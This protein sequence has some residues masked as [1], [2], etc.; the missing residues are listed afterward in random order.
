MKLNSYQ[1]EIVD[2]LAQ[3]PQVIEACPGSGKTRTLENLVAA[4]VES[5]ADPLRI[6]IFTF[7]TKAAAEARK[8]IAGTL[9]P[10]ASGEELAFFENPKSNNGFSREW[11]EEKPERQ[12]LT[13]WTCTIHALSY[14]LLK[15]S[16]YKLRVLSGKAKWEA[17]NLIKDGLAELD[18]Q[19]SPKA[20]KLWISKAIIAL[21]Q[22]HEAMQW[23]AERLP[24]DVAWH[25]PDLAELYRR[26]SDFCKSRNLVDFDMMQSRVVYL[27]RNSAKFKT[28]A[29]SLFDYI[30]VDEAQDTSPQQAE[31]LFSLAQETGN[32]VFC[33]DVDQ[34]LFRFRGARPEVMRSDFDSIWPE[35]QRFNLPINYRSTQMIVRT[36]ATL[37]GQNYSNNGQYL[38]PFQSRPNAP[39]GQPVTYSEFGSFDQLAEEVSALVAQS[40][41]PGDWFVLSRTRAECAAIHTKLVANGLPAINKSG[42]MLFGS[43][44]IRKVLA[45]ARLA[46]NYQNSRDDLEI[47]GEIANVATVNFR[48]PWTRRRHLPGCNNTKSWVNCGCPIIAEEG[49]DYSHSRF[50]GQKAIEAAGSWQGVI[51]QLD[52]TNRGGFPTSRA[53]G[54]K[55]LVGFVERLETKTGAREC[56][57]VIIKDC[58]LPW[59]AA[60]EGV[61]DTDL[62]ENGKVEDFDVLLSLCDPEMTVEQFLDRVEELSQGGENGNEAESVLVGTC[63]WSKGAERPRVAVNITRMP[64]VPPTR[65]PGMLPTGSAPAIEEERRLLFVAMT[66]AKEECHLLGALEWNGQEQLQSQFIGEV[67]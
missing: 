12:M 31:I 26:Y 10:D 43:P 60:E 52:E 55:D 42:G 44:H 15:A 1:Q 36:A 46:C 51:D 37:I 67:L 59:L 49:A 14:R 40:E 9:W 54:A 34:S 65:K 8:R 6:G 7:S 28:W 63:H 16:G 18:W 11:A 56:L 24:P 33:G 61:T 58:V 64:I 29:Q 57:N 50:Y 41:T 23:Y 2:N 20:V 4:L 62:A 47:L 38:K 3:G 39:E 45:Y 22:P 21:I 66:R 5:G 17:D 35:V 48:A 27:L 53:K 32:I 19:E 13:D 25:A 30:L